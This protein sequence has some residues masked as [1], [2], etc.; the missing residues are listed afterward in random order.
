[1]PC[2]VFLFLSRVELLQPPPP[3][4]R[5]SSSNF[6]GSLTRGA[7]SAKCWKHT[8]TWWE[9]WPRILQLSRLWGYL[10][11]LIFLRWHHI[12]NGAVGE[13]RVWLDFFYALRRE[14][15]G[16]SGCFTV[17][18]FGAPAEES[19]AAELFSLG[20]ELSNEPMIVTRQ[21]P[22]KK[23]SRE[24]LHTKTRMKERQKKRENYTKRWRIGTDEK[25]NDRTT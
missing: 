2:F 22:T 23:C 16:S 17:G 12:T 20:P 5:Y 21:K 9:T 10:L 1:M 8:R 6:V 18:I 13:R 19:N 7:S 3:A 24:E 15:E 11:Q 25:G 14:I 4:R